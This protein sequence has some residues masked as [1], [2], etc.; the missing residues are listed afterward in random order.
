[1]ADDPN[2]G[3]V[4]V[5]NHLASAMS[6]GAVVGFLAG[7][8]PLIGVLMAIIWYA[9]AIS[10]TKTVKAWIAHR[11]VRSAKYAAARAATKIAILQERANAAKEKLRQYENSGGT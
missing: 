4:S 7:A 9:I 2:A 1:M 10:E 11:Q 8:L 6:A 3:A 5:V